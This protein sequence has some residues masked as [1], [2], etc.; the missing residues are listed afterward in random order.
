MG[1]AEWSGLPLADVLAEATVRPDAVELVF[2]GADRGMVGAVGRELTFERSLPL[3]DIGGAYLVV[4]MNG[5][6]LPEHHGAPVR[7]LVPGRYGMASVKWLARITALS[8]R[9]SSTTIASSALMVLAG[10]CG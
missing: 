10:G 4:A 6:P 3:A 9:W 7:L 5:E 1:T 2:V 8:G